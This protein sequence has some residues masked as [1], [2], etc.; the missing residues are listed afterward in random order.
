MNKCN[1][2]ISRHF[3]NR[4]IH[5]FF[6]RLYWEAICHTGQWN[7][8]RQNTAKLKK[9]KQKKNRHILPVYIRIHHITMH[10]VVSKYVSQMRYTYIVHIGSPLWRACLH[11]LILKS[12][13]C[14]QQWP[15]NRQVYAVIQEE[16]IGV[17]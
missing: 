11:I 2:N 3:L 16:R 13:S 15:R 12:S 7:T 10:Y 4:M 14:R 5:I 1:N 9:T 8:K 17:T 6:Y